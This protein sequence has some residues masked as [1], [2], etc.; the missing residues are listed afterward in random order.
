[1]AKPKVKTIRGKTGG[2]WKTPFDD[3]LPREAF[4]CENHST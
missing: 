3:P 1:M 4:L 2:G